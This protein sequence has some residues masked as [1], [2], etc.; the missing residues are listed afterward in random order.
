MVVQKSLAL[1]VLIGYCTGT[2]FCVAPK[3]PARRDDG[4][5]E[6]SLR[7]EVDLLKRRYAELEG[8]IKVLESGAL[9]PRAQGSMFQGAGAS[10]KDAAQ[11]PGQGAGKAERPV[12][13]QVLE[14]MLKGKREDAHSAKTSLMKNAE[15]RSASS[16]SLMLRASATLDK[17]YVL[18]S[19]KNLVCGDAPSMIV[20]GCGHSLVFPLQQSDSGLLHIKKDTLLA[21]KDITLKNFASSRVLFEEGAGLI[22]GTQTVIELAETEVMLFD[23]VISGAV[24]VRGNGTIL[25]DDGH[26]I[27]LQE[28]AS[29]TFDRVYFASFD[30]DVFT[31]S[32]SAGNTILFR[33][34]TIFVSS[35]FACS[36]PLVFEHNVFIAGGGVFA[37]SC[38]ITLKHNTRLM[39]DTGMTIRALRDS[40]IES[41][42]PS[43]T[44]FLNGCTIAAPFGLSFGQGTILAKNKNTFE[45]GLGDQGIFFS[46]DHCKVVMLPS[47]SFELV[48]G[49]WNFDEY[50]LLVDKKASKK[51]H[52]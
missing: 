33:N 42:G 2:L 47:G 11:N 5:A 4:G 43:T 21:T 50:K 48:A 3:Q 28:G 7:Q 14:Q 39:I 24:T 22:F 17:D 19:T 16:L 26:A 23:W 30:Q 46:P 15:M 6:V 1:C 35:Q 34:S 49:A 41:E 18:S 36:I 13:L 27:I 32:A 37:F 44:I 31:G 9:E 40:G 12:S 29:L 8:R 20:D 25:H 52:K 45:A 51:P 10:I 38:P